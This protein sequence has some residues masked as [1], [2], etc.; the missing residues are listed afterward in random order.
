MS[1]EFNIS[2]RHIVA[3]CKGTRSQANGFQW[4]YKD[5]IILLKIPPVEKRGERNIIQLDGDS[6]IR[7]FKSATEAHRITHI[8]RKS[9]NNCCLGIYKS[10]G[11]F[12]WKY[13]IA[14]SQ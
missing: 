13:D 7:H 1:I 14:E 4:R 11:G 8:N 10:A 5:G 9:I 3:C 12:V 6:V 2:W